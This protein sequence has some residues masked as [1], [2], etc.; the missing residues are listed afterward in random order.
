MH[1]KDYRSRGDHDDVPVG[2]GLVGYERVLPAAVAAGAEWLVVEQ[3]EVG[4]VP[5]DAV[6][7]SLRAVRR[8]LAAA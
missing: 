6:E 1:V 3:D 5:F 4:D 2:D 8:I 7:R